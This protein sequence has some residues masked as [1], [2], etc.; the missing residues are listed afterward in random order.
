MGEIIAAFNTTLDGSYDHRAGIPDEEI[1]QHY[2]QL[3]QN[4]D[5]ILYG[6]KT[7]ELMKF[8]Q[9][10]AAKRTGDKIMDDFALAMDKIPKLLFSRGQYDP[11]WSSARLAQDNLENEVASLQRRENQKVLIGSR[12]LILQ[13]LDMQKVDELQL[14]V[15]PVIAGDGLSLFADLKGQIRLQLKKIQT[16]R[17]GAVILYYTLPK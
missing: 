17:G 14:C 8:W 13:L 16:F 1:H 12:S 9:P 3:L 7:F 15:Y 4:A 2:T 6:R 5:T 10:I 11:E